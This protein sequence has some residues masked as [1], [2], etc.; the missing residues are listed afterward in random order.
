MRI[1]MTE[2]KI[3]FLVY[4]Y[5]ADVNMLMYTFLVF[6]CAFYTQLKLYYRYNFA[7]WFSHQILTIFF[8]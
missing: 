1:Q 2:K 3:L 5:S 4:L 6:S 7:F 8:T